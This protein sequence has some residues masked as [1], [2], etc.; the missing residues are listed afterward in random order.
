M[1]GAGEIKPL[2]YSAGHARP[3]GGLGYGGEIRVVEAFVH[4]LAV[5]PPPRRHLPVVPT[6]AGLEADDIAPFRIARIAVDGTPQELR[7][8]LDHTVVERLFAEA[9]GLLA[10]GFGIVILLHDDIILEVPVEGLSKPP[11]GKAA[12]DLVLGPL[13][14]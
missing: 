3:G 7:F 12:L 8:E 13:S 11:R 14:A 6:L 4:H 10:T 5:P 1:A 9:V 2:A